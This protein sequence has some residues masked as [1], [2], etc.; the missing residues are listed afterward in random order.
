[1]ATKEYLAALGGD[2]LKNNKMFS[3]PKDKNKKKSKKQIKMFE[4]K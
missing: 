2:Y 1:M 4:S 3:G